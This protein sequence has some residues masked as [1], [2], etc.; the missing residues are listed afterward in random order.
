[1]QKRQEIIRIFWTA[2]AL[3]FVLGM[4]TRPQTVFE[5]AIFGL[6]TWWNIVFPSLLPF[7]IV[8][9]LLMNFGVVHF[10]GVLLEPVM[11]PL[12]NVPGTGSFVLAIGYTSGYPIGAMV[13]ARLRAQKLCTRIE[14]ERLMSFTNN[15]SPLFMLVA[16]AVG[17]F[18]NAALGPLIAGA[19]YMAN[20]TLGLLLRFYGRH[21]PEI[22]PRPAGEKNT[23]ILK[24][25]LDELLA[26]QGQD[27]RPPGQ[28]IGDAV[29]NSIN[30]LLTI[31]GFIILFA[32][33]INLL[34]QAGIINLIARALGLVLVPMGLS[35]AVLPAL[36]SG[37]F[38][39]TTGTRLASEAAAPLLHRLVAVAM[40]LAWSG[41]S[42]QAQA[43]SM[44]AGTDIRMRPFI[45]VRIAHA[46]L[47]AFYTCLLF[48]PATALNQ[49]LIQPVFAPLFAA[50]PISAWSISFLS[51]LILFVILGL[52][53][54]L[55]LI[56]ILLTR[57][58]I[59]ILRPR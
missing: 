18:H 57:L 24:R 22:L 25:A 15:S 20:L 36:A 59:L 11:R 2:C 37:L 14:A 4:I 6:G 12:F 26:H 23:W 7:F 34:T 39:M 42:I 29:K 30:N 49:Y 52:M 16:V 21:D 8:S 45:L 3:L 54:F 47:A 48:G 32:V 55:A 46:I 40:I 31:G 43:A 17:M 10:M 27:K 38:E 35:P 1:M 5:G 33:I 50:R 58:R 44:I 19:H 28:I 41:L 56:I 9:E 13:T 53:I 51:L